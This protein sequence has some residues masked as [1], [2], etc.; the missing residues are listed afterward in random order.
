MP[1][2]TGCTGIYTLV[3]DFAATNPNTGAV[4]SA[5][6]PNYLGG[7]WYAFSDTSSDPARRNDT[8]L[9]KS[10]ILLSSGAAKWLPLVGTA[11]IATAQL[12]KNDTGSDFLYHKQAGWA[13][14][15]TDLPGTNPDGSLALPSLTAV[16]FDLYA[17][18]ALASVVPGADFDA[19]RVRRIAFKISKA[20]VGDAQAY[21]VDIPASA[22]LST[23][24]NSFCVDVSQL[25]QPGW[26]VKDKLEG[27]VVPFAPDDLTKLSWEIK[28]EDQ[29][30]STVH[31]TSVPSTFGVAN[32]KLY[33]VDPAGIRAAGGRTSTALRASYSNGLHLSY[34]V[35]GPGARIEVRHLDG[36]HVASFQEAAAVQDLSLPLSL[37]RGTYVVT[38]RGMRARQAAVLSVAR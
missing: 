9:G 35:D 25:H 33:G 4:R 38:V 31:A 26:Y 23:T 29:A 5:S 11:A 12:E 3:D 36:S 34:R 32:V 17:G 18:A 19:V 16:S 14:I 6:D 20:S 2:G 15:G 28:I 22:A 1:L 30:D 8:A 13:D 37:S 7:A 27:K 24:S 10:R 21:S